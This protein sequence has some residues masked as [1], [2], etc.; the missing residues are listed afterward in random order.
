MARVEIVAASEDR[1]RGEALAD[2]L[3][4]RGHLLH[5]EVGPP[6][7]HGFGPVTSDRVVVVLWSAKAAF[8]RHRMAMER[9]ALDAWAAE[10]LVLVRL[11]VHAAAV[12]LRDLPAIEMWR[13]VELA[14]FE[15]VA[16]AV[17]EAAKPPPPPPSGGLPSTGDRD[18]ATGAFEPPRAE[19]AG[20]PKPRSH[21]RVLLAAA[22]GGT[23]ILGAIAM[24]VLTDGSVAPDDG[25]S[26]A[27]G[28]VWLG[29]GALAVLAVGLFVAVAGR[30]AATRRL[31]APRAPDR[32][33][34]SP[35]RGAPAPQP[36]PAPAA[37]KP[38]SPAPSS[39]EAAAD[40]EYLFLSYAHRDKDL[41]ESVIEATR[42][43]GR[44]VWT[45]A[46]LHAGP[47]WAGEIVKAMK[48]SGGV[49]VCCSVGAFES[50][51]VKREVYLAD[52]FKKRL[53]P[54][55]L[56]NI[57]PPDDFLYFFADRQWLHAHHADPTELRAQLA[58]ALE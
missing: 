35:T 41:V 1:E 2:F 32:A 18:E 16:N 42:A 56:E 14:A 10:R 8:S 43:V 19:P 4:K 45:D 52:R 33:A 9:R 48:A 29:A 6:T 58:E 20:P 25:G 24:V 53:L 22:I 54:V 40:D 27:P 7:V 47:G 51:H 44:E 12:G 39:E 50:D 36:A 21:P 3:V 31:P 28:A 34:R 30:G 55:F 57:E 37:P 15:A 23:L 13:T 49:I 38:P 26:G 17:R 5:G 46:S 11:D